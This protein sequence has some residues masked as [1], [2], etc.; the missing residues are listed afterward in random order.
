M[1]TKEC[2]HCKK[3][4]ELS[5][6]HQGSHWCKTCVS[7]YGKEYRASE[8][9]RKRN[10]DYQQQWRRKNRK[11]M[12]ASMKEYGRKWREKLKLDFIKAYGGKCECCGEKTSEFL[13]LEHKNGG[14]FRE[15]KRMN[16]ITLMNRLK[17]ADW[18]Q[19]NYT[20]LCFNCNCAS[21]NG[22]CP[23]KKGGI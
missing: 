11:R 1:E 16:T 3:Q 22:E 8:E 21:R 9:I 18:P 13:T 4:K 7:E 2:N 14:G 15:R 6:F 23:H 5:K 19:G 17:K 20:V 10:H 12:L